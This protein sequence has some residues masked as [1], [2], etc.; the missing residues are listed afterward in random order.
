MFPNVGGICHSAGRGNWWA[1]VPALDQE[2]RNSEMW[3]F[4]RFCS[5]GHLQTRE[6]LQH[7]S[8]AASSSS[9]PITRGKQCFL[10]LSEKTNWIYFFS[11]ILSIPICTEEDELI[12]Q[13]CKWCLQHSPSLSPFPSDGLQEEAVFPQSTQPFWGY[14]ELSHTIA[15][16]AFKI[17]HLGWPQQVLAG[18][19]HFCFDFYFTPT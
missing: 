2:A 5:K 3:E 8:N 19:H 1:E 14:E 15:I 11:W 10:Y 12:S 18:R 7:I 17:M 4:F 9:K 6:M 16:S 13:I